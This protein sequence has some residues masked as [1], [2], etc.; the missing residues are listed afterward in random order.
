MTSSRPASLVTTTIVAAYVVTTAHS[1]SFKNLPYLRNEDLPVIGN[2]PK[3]MKNWISLSKDV[4]FLEADS[5]FA[6][7]PPPSNKKKIRRHLDEGE[8]DET[9]TSGKWDTNNP[10]S[11]QP[12]VEGISEYDEYQ[13][14]WRMLGFMIDCNPTTAEYEN[15]SQHSNS[16]DATDDECARYV[17]WAAV[18]LLRTLLSWVLSLEKRRKSMHFQFFVL[19]WMFVFVCIVCRLVL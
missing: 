12:F 14:A 4:E 3:Q 6:K 19:S 11:V 2:D 1:A 13:Q 17:L 15:E 18:S 7:R 9:T 8:D 5:K 10:Y 16:G